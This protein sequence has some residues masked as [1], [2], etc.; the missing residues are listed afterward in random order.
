MSKGR[1]LNGRFCPMT[2]HWCR[3]DCQWCYQDVSIDD[4]GVDESFDCAINL[5]AEITIQEV[6]DD[7][8]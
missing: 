1:V 5:I 4:D 2:K 6:W 7:Y 8:A 3:T